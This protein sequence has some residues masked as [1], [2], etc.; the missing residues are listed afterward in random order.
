MFYAE[1]ITGA[2]NRII[3]LIVDGERPHAIEASNSTDHDQPPRH[4]RAAPKDRPQ[5]EQGPSGLSQR[6]PA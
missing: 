4:G 1:T 2:E 6:R 3:S 5:A